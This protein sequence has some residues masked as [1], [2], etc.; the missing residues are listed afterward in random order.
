[1]SLVLWSSFAKPLRLTLWSAARLDH[2]LPDERGPRAGPIYGR[3]P[4]FSVGPNPDS[5]FQR[6]M[7][8]GALCK[9]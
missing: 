5:F 6:G 1:M 8:Q 4:G 9:S 7:G 3:F 2:A